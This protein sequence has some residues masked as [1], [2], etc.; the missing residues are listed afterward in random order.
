MTLQQLDFLLAAGDQLGVALPE[1]VDLVRAAALLHP[2][3]DGFGARL[4]NG[5]NGQ[6]HAVD[7]QLRSHTVSSGE[8]ELVVVLEFLEYL[9]QLYQKEPDRDRFNLGWAA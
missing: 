4:L 1:S 3:G 6:G 5:L 2:E 8:G 9:G 7:V